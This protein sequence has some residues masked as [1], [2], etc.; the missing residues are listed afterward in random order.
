MEALAVPLQASKT[1]QSVDCSSSCGNLLN[2]SYP[3]RF[4]G[5]PPNCGNPEYELSCEGD[6]PYLNLLERKYA[7]IAIEYKTGMIRVVDY[8][9][10]RGK[11]SSHLISF[12]VDYYFFLDGDP[13]ILPESYAIIAY[14]NCSAPIYGVPFIP[15]NSC[16]NA[17][18]SSVHLYAILPSTVNASGLPPPC[19]V[20]ARANVLKPAPKRDK[21]YD[22]TEVRDMLM[23]GFE[24]SWGVPLACRNCSVNHLGCEYVRTQEVQPE[25][26]DQ[27]RCFG[28]PEVQ[29]DGWK[30]KIIAFFQ[31][32]YDLIWISWY[33]CTTGLWMDSTVEEFLSSYRYETPTRYSYSQI[34]KM[35]RG[36]SDKLGQGGFGSVYKGKLRAGQP[37]AIK[38]LSAKSNGDVQDFINEVA[39]IGRIHHV[40]VVRLIGFCSEGSKRA[41]IYEFMPNGSLDKDIYPQEG[42]SC[43]L[44][45]E[46]IYEIALGIAHG[47]QYL[48]RGCD[49]KIL[50]FDIKPH[51]I[52]LDDKFAPKVSDFGLSKFYPVDVSFVS[53]TAV[54]GTVGY[55]APELFYKNAGGVSYKSDVYSFGMLLMEMAGRRKNVNAYAKNSSQIY[56]PLWVYDKLN[57]DE[58]IGMEDDAGEDEK[59]VIKKM[60]IV[61]LWCIQMKPA[62]RP[63]MTKVVEMLEGRVERLQ[64]PAKPFLSSPERAPDQDDEID[65]DVDASK[66]SS[67]YE[68]GS[69]SQNDAESSVI[70]IIED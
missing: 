14:L 69:T 33:E 25:L 1:E 38:I 26:Q 42:K 66:S 63:S 59:E 17:S 28:L 68:L 46:K 2:I 57:Q 37:V 45:C 36:F 22:Y 30:Y 54:R 58:D 55:I 43:P 27:V 16:F 34:K 39:T 10:Q 31:K 52:L 29:P 15:A 49:M 60:L 48:H 21:K 64:L 62:D 61:A 47:I 7:V 32:I 3:F 44:S 50:H 67:V 23:R 19:K 18:S 65:T 41:L 40:N 70:H 5:D 35:T 56:F 51:N 11:C 6:H 9:L 8:E 24:L 13:Y 53:V 20:V 12:G 4:K